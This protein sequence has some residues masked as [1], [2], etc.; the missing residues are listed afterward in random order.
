MRCFLFI[1]A[2]SFGLSLGPVMA[3]GPGDWFP[4]EISALRENAKGGPLD[5]TQLNEAPAGKSGFVAVQG[6][7]FVDGAGK[8]VKFFGTNVVAGGCFPS[9]TD[10]PKI[11]AH[12]AAM[13]HNIVRFHFLDNQWGGDSLLKGPGYTEWND[14]AMDRLHF[15]MAELNKVGIYVN[16]NL[17]VGRNY[18]GSPKEAP[19]MSKG[20][21]LFHE[22]YSRMFQEYSRKLL[23]TPN[24]YRGK[25]PAVD[26]G[27]AVIELNNE[28][29]LL[30]NPW[31]VNKLPEP[32]AAELQGLWNQWLAN[33]YKRGNMLEHYGWAKG[34]PGENLVKEQPGAETQNSGWGREDKSPE[35]STA[36]ALEGGGVRWTVTKPGPQLWSHHYNFTG[37]ELQEGGRY[38]MKFEARAEEPRKL[39]VSYMLNEGAYSNAGLNA[40]V[41]L[42]TSWQPVTLKFTAVEM[43]GKK[44]RLTFDLLNTTGTVE[45][46]KV[47]VQLMPEGYLQEGQSFEKGTVPFP[48]ADAPYKVRRDAFHFLGETEIAWALKQKAFLKLELG[49]KQPIAHSHVL[50]GGLL[51]A[52]RESLVSDFTDNHGYWQHPHFPRKQWDM[53]DWEIKNTSQIADAN[54]GT[55]AELAMQRP[56]GKPYSVSEYD[57]PAPSDYAAESLPMLAVFACQQDWD[58]IYTFTFVND[59][60]AWKGGKISGFFDQSGHPAK[61]GFMPAAALIFRQGMI[62]AYGTMTTLNV[63]ESDLWDDCA[64]TNGELWGSWRR[65]WKTHGNGLDGRLSLETATAVEITP[66]GKG[67]SRLLSQGKQARFTQWQAEQGIYTVDAGTI[68]GAFGK[69]GGKHSFA[70]A[71]VSLDIAQLDGNAHGSLLLVSLDE[72]PL[73]TSKKMLLTA[74]RRAENDGMKWNADRTSVGRDWGNGPVKVLGL[75]ADVKLSGPPATLTKLDPNGQPL[76]EGSV[77]ATVKVSPADK[78]IW[79]LLTR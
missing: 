34:G 77:T 76:G 32:F 61:E 24:P 46:R 29:T 28:N 26:A 12:L 42:T 31:W 20:I 62:P 44:T 25:A 11:S 49:V 9:K 19:E 58:A 48:T 60:R 64:K 27:V 18:P 38:E 39:T 4:F 78:T 36:S 66:E 13:G 53:G 68:C 7:H 55:L 23:T 47:A 67:A 15:F 22:P 33:N 8:R 45:L 72:N 3:D 6:E 54:G 71:G 50:F 5:L 1:V 40:S 41:D 51:G 59:P 56:A 2:L 63:K 35:R 65:A 75:T 17:H 52:R 14:D 57:I 10:A 73:A 30:M 74:M 43:R 70:Q 79:F 37:L 69:I 16:L 21:D